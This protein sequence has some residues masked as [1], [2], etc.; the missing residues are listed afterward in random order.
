MR[1]WVVDSPRITPLLFIEDTF[2]QFRSE[3]N[4][5]E[6]REAGHYL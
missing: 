5:R 3:V 6:V 4:A 1:Q 2:S